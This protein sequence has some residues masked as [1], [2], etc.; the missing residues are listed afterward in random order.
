MVIAVT[1]LYHKKV[2]AITFLHIPALKNRFE[3]GRLS[4]KRQHQKDDSKSHGLFYMEI[5]QH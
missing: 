5:I 3:K 2:T 1:I 4:N